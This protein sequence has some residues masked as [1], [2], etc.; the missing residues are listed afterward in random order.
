MMDSNNQ[1]K[2]HVTTDTNLKDMRVAQNAVIAPDGTKA[3]F[4]VIEYLPDQPKARSRVWIADMSGGEARPL[5][6]S[7]RGDI[8]PSWSPDSREVAYISRGKD[9]KDKPQ[10]HIIGADGSNDRQVCAMPNGVENAEWSPDGNHIAII[11]LEGE[12]PGEDPKVFTP[13]S[14][15]CRRLWTVRPGSDTPE[16]VTPDGFSVW[17]YAWSRDSQQFAVYYSA[18]PDLTSWYRGQIGIVAASGGVIRQVSRLTRQACALAWSPDGAQLA[19]IGGEW[20]DPDRGGGDIFILDVASGETRNLTP[21]I[22]YNPAWCAWFPNGQRLLYAGFTGVTYCIGTVN[23]ADGARTTLVKDILLADFHY[24]HLSMT[25]DM[26]QCVATVKTQHPSNVWHGTLAFTD[27]TATGIEWRQLTRL[28]PILEETLAIAPT[29]HIRY[30]G[31]DGWQIDALF[32]PPLPGTHKG[33]GLPPLVVN[34]HGGPSGAFDSG[35][36]L[37]RSQILP[38]AGFALLRVNPRGSMGGGV[39]FADAVLGDMGGKDMQDIMAGVD[40]LIERGLVDGERMGI[41]GWSY[42]GFMTAWVVTQT[43]RFKAAVMG[44][45]VCDFHSF[46]AQTNIPDWD[47]RA[48]GKEPISPLDHPDAYRERSAITY[49][50]R[51]VTPTLIV[52][53]EQDECVPVNQAYAFYRALA[54]RSLPTEL[55][56]YPREGH[57][58]TEKAHIRDYQERFL[59]WFEKYL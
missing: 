28:N 25:P 49:A 51:V 2:V 18:G 33:D 8:S 15:Q 57:G 31:A 14:G 56:I 30:V 19:Y 17:Q 38:A 16:A 29:E 12:K 9:E 6:S 34:V 50:G 41:M 40:Y 23:V 37:Y 21:G 39:A 22:T 13:G 11:S 47:M 24:P 44:A 26:R 53:G 1:H 10:L 55:V 3:A 43:T 58:P 7:P 36:D 54:E 4:V 46:H 5:T 52:H 35:W 42:G 48:L 32:T 59:N 45:G 27:N 20:S